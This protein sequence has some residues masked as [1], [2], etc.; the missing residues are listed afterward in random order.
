M[1]DF[2]KQLT[3]MSIAG[4]FLN[5]S[6]DLN[7]H[8]L[9]SNVVKI[10]WTVTRD[11]ANLGFVLAIILIALATIIRMESYAMKKTLWKLIVAALLINFSLVIA[12]LIIDFGG[13][14]TEFFINKATNNNPVQLAASLANSFQIQQILIPK[15]E[16][17]LQGIVSGLVNNLSGLTTMV[18][19]SF[20]V[21][22]LTII[23]AIAMAGLA[24]M[25][26]VR[27][28][29]LTILLILMPLAWLAWIFPNFEGKWKEWWSTFMQWVFFGPM[30]SFAIYLAIA[31]AKGGPTSQALGGAQTYGGALDTLGLTIK[32]LGGII[33]Q[34]AAVIGI[35]VGGLIA[36]NKMAGESAKFAVKA[37]GSVRGAMTTG[38]LLK[39]AEG[40]RRRA[41]QWAKNAGYSPGGEGKDGETKKPKE[42]WVNI[43]ANTLSGIP[44]FRGVGAKLA[45]FGASS[46]KDV[47]DYQK[48]LG[49]LTPKQ[50]VLRANTNLQSDIQKAAIAAE[51]GKQGL[52]EGFKDK[53][54]PE[55]N[56]P[57]NDEKLTE[58]LKSAQKMGSTKEILKA[59]P[60]LAEKISTAPDAISKAVGKIKAKEADDISDEALKNI[61]V[62]ASLSTAHMQTIAKDGTSKQRSAMIT[63]IKSLKTEINGITDP[64]EKEKRVKETSFKEKMKFIGSNI[65]MQAALEQDGDQD[66][67]K[68]ANEASVYEQLKKSSS[69]K[70]DINR[71]IKMAKDVAEL[72]LKEAEAERL[73]QQNQNK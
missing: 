64:T 68:L 60:D 47:E 38:L 73:K 32:N 14:L 69:I 4:W 65:A 29:H 27:Y 52:T 49:G 18:A 16:G 50:L 23:S 11:I 43:A 55:N 19:S 9:Q 13:M 7:N 34:M 59:R 62:V 66:L 30:A 2:S 20:F 41:A 33:A 51:I 22:I 10:G 36:A 26:F 21:A 12:G 6:F 3:L 37:A 56:I 63:S 67:L 5:L 15:D 54:H 31:I 53:E 24:V 8:I 46:K 72:K 1:P 57:I 35:L 48:E 58:L 40:V 70:D 39:G 17:V 71:D 25:F 61:K 44:G 42:S 28:I 45:G